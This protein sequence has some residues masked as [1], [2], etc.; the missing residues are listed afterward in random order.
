MDNQPQDQTSGA[1]EP[2]NKTCPN[3]QRQYRHQCY[4]QRSP[5]RPAAVEA[6]PEP[7]TS[8]VDPRLLIKN[9]PD[10]QVQPKPK[11]FNQKTL[12][13][14]VLPGIVGMVAAIWLINQE[15]DPNRYLPSGL[16]QD[17]IDLPGPVQVAPDNPDP[18]S[19]NTEPDNP[20]TGV[21]PA[22]PG[23]GPAQPQP[24]EPQ[25]P[26]VEPPAQ[27]EPTIPQ[28]IE[29]RPQPN[30]PNQ[31][32]PEPEPEPPVPVPNPKPG[33]EPITGPD[34]LKNLGLVKLSNL[35]DY[36][37]PPGSDLNITG[38]TSADDLIRKQ[39]LNR[40]W[41]KRSVADK[42]RLL[43][44]GDRSLL[45][46]AAV[47]WQDL[48]QAASQ[49]G[50]QIILVNGYID[51][52]D[53]RRTFL[54]RLGQQTGNLTDNINQ[55]LDVTYPPGFS[56][57]QTGW[58]LDLSLAGQPTSLNFKETAT[59]QWLARDDFYQLKRWGW[60]PVHKIDE[61]ADQSPN[62]LEIGYIGLDSL[63]KNNPDQ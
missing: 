33:P 59:Y 37:Y 16:S 52:D 13:Y 5:D 58:V 31:P 24:S 50:F 28:P 62:S 29:P 38:N 19:S 40:G 17:P 47:A 18:A 44:L 21:Q 11:R 45:A 57:H 8:F 30:P 22:E 2:E 63:R 3:C 6:E 48:Q 12:I 20:A 27:P 10:R 34:Q 54:A 1:V 9:Q 14:I 51:P 49:A 23:A 61:P 56:R 32:E 46:P 55:T 60:V 4:C 53:Q 39:A 35:F 36:L 25:P 26:A 42:S 7:P 41:L 43:H 15:A